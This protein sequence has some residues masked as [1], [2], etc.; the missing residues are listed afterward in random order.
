MEQ[1][2]DFIPM[3]APTHTVANTQNKIVRT[4]A[5]STMDGMADVKNFKQVDD[6][7]HLS[8]ISVQVPNATIGEESAAVFERMQG[9]YICYAY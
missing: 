1:K 5:R 9:I 7:V 3:Q 2:I 4:V 6:Q 8:G